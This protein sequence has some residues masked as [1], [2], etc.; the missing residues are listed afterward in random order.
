MMLMAGFT[1]V[2]WI[3]IVSVVLKLDLKMILMLELIII[4]WIGISNF[5]VVFMWLCRLN[6]EHTQHR[7]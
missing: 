5:S 7:A 4:I 1:F 6:L 2:I 3:S